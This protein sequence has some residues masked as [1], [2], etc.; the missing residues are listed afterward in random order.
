MFACLVSTQS[1]Q[2]HSRNRKVP[3]FF[4][5]LKV[6][7]LHSVLVDCGSARCFQQEEGL[8]RGLWA[9]RSPIDSSSVYLHMYLQQAIYS[10]CS[11]WLI[12]LVN[13]NIP[14]IIIVID[15]INIIFAHCSPFFLDFIILEISEF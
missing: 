3:G 1:W 2:Q 13:I 11:G 10:A 4:S 12:I 8:S 9:L 15:N 14:I 6:S 7:V 5:L